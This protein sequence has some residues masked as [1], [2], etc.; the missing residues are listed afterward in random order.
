MTDDFEV[1][2]GSSRKGTGGTLIEVESIYRHPAYHEDSH[3]Y[4]FA[5]LKLEEPIRFGKTKQPVR[6]HE[7]DAST[8]DGEMLTVTGWGD[9]KTATETDRKLRSTQVLKVNDNECRKIYRNRHKVTRNMICAGFKRGGKDSCQG[10]SGGPLVNANK[11]IVGVVSWGTG[12][13]LPNYPGVYARV[14]AVSNWI[15]NVI[16][17]KH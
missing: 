1:R 15:K 16:K 2:V 8:S 13:A 4:D 9:T 17:G 3:D 11:T 14:A 10:D 5:I 6:L 7:Q 12:C